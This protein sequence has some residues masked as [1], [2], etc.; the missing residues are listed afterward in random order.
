MVDGEPGEAMAYGQ[1]GLAGADDDG[2]CGAN[3]TCSGQRLAAA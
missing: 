2:R 3:R 1:P